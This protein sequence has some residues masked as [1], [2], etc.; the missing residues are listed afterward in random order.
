[1]QVEPTQRSHDAATEDV[2]EFQPRD[3]SPTP[4]DLLSRK[5]YQSRSSRKFITSLKHR[6]SNERTTKGNTESWGPTKTAEPT[7][8]ITALPRISSIKRL[9]THKRSPSPTHGRN[10]SCQ[11]L[12]TKFLSSPFKG[13]S[14]EIGSHNK[15]RSYLQK[16]ISL[17][18][19][20]NHVDS[21][22]DSDD[23]LSGEEEKSMLFEPESV[24]ATLNP[25]P[26]KEDTLSPPPIPTP[27]QNQRTSSSSEE[28]LRPMIVRESTFKLKETFECA[29]E[30]GD[31]QE[32]VELLKNMFKAKKDR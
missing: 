12:G 18:G 29:A 27:S 1:M 26:R 23:I 2:A 10:V 28:V 16:A 7:Y 20:Q 13:E 4:S 19:D 9:L 31:V 8:S 11:V 5:T 25:T 32:L 21:L 15:V 17:P 3:P 6:Y 14:M 30:H 24:P 22:D